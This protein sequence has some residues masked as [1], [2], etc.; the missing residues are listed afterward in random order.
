MDE[1]AKRKEYFVADPGWTIREAIRSDKLRQYGKYLPFPLY[2]GLNVVV[3]RQGFVDYL[4]SITSHFSFSNSN[5]YS[6]Y[7][8]VL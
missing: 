3:I 4:V 7:Y 8:E 2:F 1:N 5:N 6:S